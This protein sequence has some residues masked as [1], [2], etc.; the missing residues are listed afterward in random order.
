MTHII[1]KSLPE[2]EAIMM[3]N[4]NRMSRDSKLRK[5]KEE[6]K[7]LKKEIKELKEQIRASVAIEP[8]CESCG[9][10]LDPTQRYCVECWDGPNTTEKDEKRYRS[11]R[12]E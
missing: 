3:E 10:R 9:D 6:N 12:D 7:R 2:R 5:L 11:E 1:G 8:R 4:A